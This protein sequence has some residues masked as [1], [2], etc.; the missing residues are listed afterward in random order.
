VTRLFR[1]SRSPHLLPELE[2]RSEDLVAVL[3]PDDFDQEEYESELPSQRELDLRSYVGVL[4]HLDWLEAAAPG[5]GAGIAARTWLQRQALAASDA[6][7][8][9]KGFARLLGHPEG[10]E[11]ELLPEDT[12]LDRRLWTLY[13]AWTDRYGRTASS[14]K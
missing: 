9:Y 1:G 14:P 4:D 11:W 10:V 7:Y 2:E 8:V 3:E 6:D 12:D 13:R 5:F